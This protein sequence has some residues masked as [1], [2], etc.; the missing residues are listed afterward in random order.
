MQIALKISDNT[1]KGKKYG[2]EYAQQFYMGRV[3]F[4]GKSAI[5]R[6]EG[7]ILSGISAIR[8]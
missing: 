5:G 2:V 8:K 4:A 3:K 6:A 7:V 1:C